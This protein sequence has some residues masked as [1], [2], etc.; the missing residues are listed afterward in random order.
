[1]FVKGM[2]SWICDGTLDLGSYCIQRSM[3]DGVNLLFLGV[4]CLLLLVGSIRK[5]YNISIRS[6]DWLFIVVSICC[7]L[8]SIAYLVLGFWNLIAKNDGHSLGS[9]LVSLVRVLVWISFSVS[10]L[11]QLSKWI[12]ILNSVWW[13]AYFSL[14]SAL[15]IEIISATGGIQIIDIVQWLVNFL[16]LICAFK[17][18]KQM[19][20]QPSQEGYSLSE[21]LVVKNVENSR[22]GPEEASFLSKLSFTWIGP[23]LSV[24][25]SKPLVLEDI[26]PLVSE[27]EA[28][29]AYQNFAQAWDT[30]LREKGSSN[31]KNLALLAITKVYLKENISVAIYAFLRTISIVV[32]PLILYGF[33]NYATRREEN[34]NEG[35]FVLGCLIISKVVES[36]SQRHWFFNSRKSGMRMRSALMVAVYQKQIKLSSLGRRRHSTGEVVNYVAVDAYRMG[37]FPWWFHLAW[38]FVLQLFLAIGV[39]F[40][41]IGSGAL[42]G[43]I[44]LVICCFLN[45]PFAKLLQKCQFQCMVAQD[46]RL[47]ATSEIL[48]SM[49]IIKLQSW[50]EKF[51]NL[52]ESSRENEFKWLSEAQLKKVYGTILYWMSPTI[53]SSATFFGCLLL[54]SAP[55]NASTIFTVLATLRTM[56]EPVRMIPEALSAIIQVKVSFDRLNAFLLDDELKDD[57]IRRYPVMHNIEKSIEIQDGIFSWDPE[58]TINPTLLEINLEVGLGQKIAVC[59]SVGAGKSSLLYAILGEIPKIS[60]TVSHKRTSLNCTLR[61]TKSVSNLNFS[62]L[63]QTG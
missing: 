49:K 41:I 34:L 50:E 25:H 54:G 8:T 13:V 60:G 57:G 22:A 40:W 38:S 52:I 37:E 58:S 5:H 35:V 18:I 15:N 1:M 47:R 27:N 51:K 12:R 36:L 7:L 33:V 6:R 20:S 55:L 11:L 59:G 26:P 29:L 61:I 14:F 28:K 48:N 56:G 30:T 53:V 2:F 43:L 44:P 24:G 62:M 4:F 63:C 21:P 19:L 17:N 3:I 31:T 9:L 10:L 32:S 23:L 42:F 39:L 16:L 45:V 46:E